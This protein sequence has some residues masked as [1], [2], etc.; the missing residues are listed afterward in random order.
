MKP[1]IQIV[2]QQ[3]SLIGHI[4]RSDIDYSKHAYRVAALWLTNDSKEVLIAQRKLTK[5]SDPGKWG[6]AVAGTVDEGEN[7]EVNIYKEA[8]EEI[9]LVGY[10]FEA[11]PKIHVTTPRNYFC[12]WYS[13]VVNIE[14]SDFTAQEEE[15]E[16]LAWVDAGWLKEDIQKHPEKYISNMPSLIPLFL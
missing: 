15:V 2:D 8:E 1:R 5:K 3:D 4:D 13:V 6:P 7:Y 11:G 9:G 10:A 16:K 12:Q 14:I